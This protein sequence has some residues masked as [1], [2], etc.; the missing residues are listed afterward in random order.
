MA[1]PIG[2]LCNIRCEYCFYLEKEKLYPDAKNRSAFTMTDETLENYVRRYIQSQPE[3]LKEIPFAW[4]GGEPTLLGVRFYEKAVEY[5]QKY[6][7]AGV[8][9]LNAFQTNGILVGDEFASFF[10]DHGFLVGVSI[11]GPE[12]LHNRYR[13]DRVGQGTFK[14]VMAG[15]EN[16]KKHGVDFNTLTVVQENNADH[17]VEVYNFLTSI[18][19]TYLQFIPIVEPSTKAREARIGDDPLS[20]VN[21]RSVRPAQW[22]S[23][24]NGV[25]HEWR[26]KDIGRIFVQ[27]FDMILGIYAGYPASLC[28]HSKECGRAMAIEHNGDVYSCD[29]FVSPEYFLGNLNHHSVTEIIDQ[30][31]QKEFG[32]SKYT[33]LPDKCKTCPYLHLCYGACPKDRLIQTKSGKLNYL[34]QGYF[35]FYRETKPYFRAMTKA[36]TARRPAAD[37]RAFFGP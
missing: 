31:A 26:K 21:P 7:P 1:K 2:A 32:T 4:Q 29:H 14:D 8:K 5:Q 13:V 24:L 33:A 22:G 37:Y 23:F 3:G 17:P 16:L 36:L 18:G 12:E 30:P 20:L 35:D 27:H 11:D 9:I 25:F 19:S 6:A 15:L 28:V 10:K 34:C